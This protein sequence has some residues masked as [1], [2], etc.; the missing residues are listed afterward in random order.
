MKLKVVFNGFWWSNFLTVTDAIL[1]SAILSIDTKLYRTHIYSLDMNMNTNIFKNNLMSKIN[2]LNVIQNKKREFDLEMDRCNES[3]VA[4]G[5]SLQND[6]RQ[7][8][9]KSLHLNF[10]KVEIWSWCL[11]LEIYMKGR[12]YYCNYIILMKKYK[13]IEFWLLILG[14]VSRVGFGGWVGHP[15]GFCLAV[16]TNC[17]A[18]SWWFGHWWWWWWRWTC[19]Q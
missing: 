14:F 13:K 3:S 15:W 1:K 12:Y 11:R 5:A 18:I 6:I 19:Q 9:G 10:I 4:I 17:A 2:Q 7:L 16:L 8:F